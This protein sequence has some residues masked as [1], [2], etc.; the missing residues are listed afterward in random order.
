MK[1]TLSQ[2][3]AVTSIIFFI[4]QLGSYFTFQGLDWYSKLLMKP[5]WT[6]PNW[7]FGVAWQIIY[8][9]CA[10]ILLKIYNSDLSLRLKFFIF[11]MFVVNAILNISWSY[12]F[13]YKK[14]ILSSLYCNGL[15]YISVITLMVVLKYYMPSAAMFL[16]PYAAWLSFALYL[17]FAFWRLNKQLGR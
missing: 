9:C 10:V 5:A 2:I 11:S 1:L 15:L 4:N 14:F 3:I 13:F 16:I 8:L 6:P 12:L 7:V 17:N